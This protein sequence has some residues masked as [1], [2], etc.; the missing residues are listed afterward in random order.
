MARVSRSRRAFLDHG[1]SRE[2]D[3]LALR[4]NRGRAA[5]CDSPLSSAPPRACGGGGG[6]GGAQGRGPAEQDGLAAG[7]GG[8]GGVEAA[9]FPPQG[10]GQVAE[11]R[12]RRTGGGGGGGVG[13]SG[14]LERGGR[15]VS[16]GLAEPRTIAEPRNRPSPRPETIE[17]RHNGAIAFSSHGIT[18]PWPI[19]RYSRRGLTVTGSRLPGSAGRTRSPAAAAVRRTWGSAAA[20]R[21]QSSSADAREARQLPT[22]LRTSSSCV[23]SRILAGAGRREGQEGTA[24]EISIDG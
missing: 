7:G 16:G 1:P 17:P 20:T 23:F 18:A 9:H 5:A 6:V 14:G 15:S 13:V 22:P 21:R 3:S 4:G 10:C 8:G 2:P 24:K 11:E 12:L 19:G